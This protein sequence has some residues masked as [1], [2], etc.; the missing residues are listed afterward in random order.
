MATLTETAYKARQVI[1][2]GGIGFVVTLVLW[3]S[4]GA[5]IAWYKATYPP[6][7]PPPTMDFGKLPKIEFQ[8]ESGRPALELELPTGRIPDFSDRMLVFFAPTKRSGFLDPQRAIETASALGF[9][10]KPEQPSE[11]R[12]VWNKQ[13][14]LRSVLDMDIVSGHFKLSRVWQNKPGIL[15]GS[16]FISDKQ[17]IQEA[18][19]YLARAGLLP[20]DATEN[21]KVT[22]FKSDGGKLIPALSLSD[23]EFAQIDYFRNDYRIYEKKED[24][25]DDTQKLRAQYSF[26]RPDADRGLIRLVLSG[27]SNIN[28][29]VVSLEYSY[30]RI[31]YET[32]GI[33]PIKTG[34]QAWEELKNGG[35][36]VTDKSP[37][38]GTTKIRRVLIG[39][40][41]TE[42]NHKYAMPI[43]IFLGDQN[44]VAYV[45]AVVDTVLE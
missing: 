14:D 3:F 18:N 35:G 42:A 24:G 1:K 4:G 26:Y 8:K 30:T 17:I 28:E 44:F 25:S 21:L 43:Y 32:R 10:F 16:N 41:D 20:G 36:Y 2:Y 15:A 37:K 9:I 31:E 7:P 6:A 29:K 22:Y 13:D 27:S 19:G 23:T 40:Y 45:S 38:T 39:Y 34:V 11:T 5:L 12:Y 33:Y